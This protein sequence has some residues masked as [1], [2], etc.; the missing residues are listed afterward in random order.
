MFWPLALL[1]FTPFFIALSVLV[2][3]DRQTIEVLHCLQA[4]LLLASTVLVLGGVAS[5]GSLT[6]WTLLHADA[7]SVWFVVVIGLVAS[8]GTLYAVGYMGEQM[9]RGRLSFRQFR[10]FF[11]LFDLYLGVMLLALNVES[12]GM[13]W[14]AI[15]GA[16]L[17]AALLIGFE[18]S[19]SALEAGWKFVMLSSVGIALALFGT[20]LVYYAS[21]Q[22]LGV[23]EKALSW[24]ELHLVGEQLDPSAM[25]LAF[26]FAFIGYGTKAGLV[27]MHAWLP[28]AHGEAPTPVSA[29]LS[30]N[31]LTMAVYAILRFK[32]L[33][34]QAV[35]PWYSG[36]LM[37][38]F[39]L[40]SV[41][42]ASFFLLLQRDYKRLFAYSSIE[43]IGI[44]LMGFGLGG[45]G[46]FGGLWHLLN[47]AL[48]KSAAFYGTGLVLLQHEH[49]VIARVPG[50]LRENPLAAI[51]LVVAGLALAGMPP[52]G[53]FVSEVAI[54]ADA[55]GAGPGIA[56][57]FLGLLAL[58]FAT[59]LY[60]VLRMVLGEPLEPHQTA[61]G[62]RCRLFATTAISVNLGALVWLGFQVPPGFDDLL[63]A[64]LSLLG[65]GEKGF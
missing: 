44:V 31:M 4:G 36:N 60:Q 56:T 41:S 52:F 5:S 22:I 61:I 35:G 26:I 29:M 65:A 49:K 3:R 12:L 25:S 20:I 54:A 2:L 46:V 62:S 37:V 33:A 45:I 42:L 1:I 11:V 27:P 30:A 34:D 48:S 39:G 23:S 16:T 51:A 59:L 21:E 57:L 58:A 8:T 10:H 47:H 17:S 6:G 28:D 15:E 13:M 53:L 64:T 9:D 18:R 38:G 19:K 14:I 7:L 32:I 63:E 40:L 43:H 24:P 55:Y 50:L